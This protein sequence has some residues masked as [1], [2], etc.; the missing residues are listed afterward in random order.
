MATHLIT[1]MQEL[2]NV[3][4]PSLLPTL[5]ANDIVELQNHLLTMGTLGSWTTI[6]QTGFPSGVTIRSSAGNTFTIGGTGANA[7]TEPLLGGII[8]TRITRL[9]VSNVNLHVEMGGGGVRGTFFWG[10]FATAEGVLVI[11]IFFFREKE[12]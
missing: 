10:V 4:N 8:T 1:T 6:S 5:S 11:K 9:S 2:Y 3:L 7:I 12:K